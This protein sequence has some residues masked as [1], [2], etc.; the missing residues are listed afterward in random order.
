M[1]PAGAAGPR[2]LDL[3]DELTVLDLVR[4]LPGPAERMRG[5]SADGPAVRGLDRDPCLHPAVPPKLGRRIDPFTALALTAAAELL[6]RL[7]ALRPGRTGL[8]LA[9]LLGGWSYAERELAILRDRGGRWVH[10][11]FVT[12][13]FPTAAQGEVSI[14]HGLLGRAKT[15]TGGPS[16]LG[17]AFW[18]ARDALERGVVDSVLVGA[19][20]SASGRLVTEALR[21]VEEPPHAP[22]EGAVLFALGRPAPAPNGR[23]G[24]GTL[25]DLRY[26]PAEAPSPGWP[27]TLGYAVALA[28]ALEHHGALVADATE[29]R[30]A[31]GGRQDRDA[32]ACAA[33]RAVDADLGGGYRVTVLPHSSETTDAG[34]APGSI[35][36]A[37]EPSPAL[38]R[39]IEH[40]D[41]A[42]DHA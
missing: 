26:D 20:E 15:T 30:G 6:A 28:D 8:F 32:T 9:N 3:L 24:P 33:P 41:P 12:A 29:D 36:D 19:V 7:P 5:T 38:A 27:Q 10:P 16:A 18:L 37:T 35:T 21:A 14:A 17:E 1:N 39:A 2:T 34:A 22:V 25:R 42:E 4:L 11:H 40:A 13:W 31:A 23:T